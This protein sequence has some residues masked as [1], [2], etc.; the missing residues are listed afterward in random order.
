MDLLLD[1]MPD[2]VEDTARALLREACDRALTLATAESCTG[3]LIAALLTDVEGGSHV[4]ERGFVA[5]SKAA[6][7]EMLGVPEALIEREG[8]VSKAVALAMVEGAMAKSQADIAVAVTGFAGAG[9]KPG[10][11][12]FG[13]ARRGQP[14][15]HFEAHFGNRGRALIRA[16]TARVALAMMRSAMD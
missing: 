2:D 13:C 11:V 6:K 9:E 4:F 1:K 5:Y 15:T 16:E 8:A 7:G 3:G 10:L 14:P 12:H